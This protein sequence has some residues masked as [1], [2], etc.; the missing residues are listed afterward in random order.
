LNTS[1][2]TPTTV[3]VIK[4]VM[5]HEFVSANREEI[6]RRCRVKVSTRLAPPPTKSESDF[7]V[8]MFLDQLVDELRLGV[9]RHPE[10]NRTATRH[11]N[12]LRRQGFTVSQVVHDYGDVCQAITDL[13]VETH[14]AITAEDFRT[15]NRCLD[16]AIASAVTEYGRE[17]DQPDDGGAAGEYELFKDVARDLGKSIYTAIV[18]LEVIKTGKVGI[19]GSTGTVLERSL[20]GAQEHVNQLLVEFSTVRPN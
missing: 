10:I 16:D 5:L 17:R 1:R 20:L 3:G 19:A 13:A 8:P 18:A 4:G 6:I 7:G 15:L 14:K 12:D 9:S 2:V 11:G